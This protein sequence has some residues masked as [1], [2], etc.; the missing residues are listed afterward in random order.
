MD[1]Q[2]PE[3]NALGLL[4]AGDALD[5]RDAMGEPVIDDSFLLL[6]N[7]S[8]TAVE[9]TLPG[10]DWGARWALRIDT[11]QDHMLH[12]GEL[13]AGARVTLDQNTMMVLK[14]V[15]PGRGSWRPST[16]ALEAVE[17]DG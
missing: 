8:R 1:W 10:I 16:A 9:F 12:E 11:R 14:R 13:A 15:L 7:G 4:L 5:W 2:K 6:L 3:S 17:S